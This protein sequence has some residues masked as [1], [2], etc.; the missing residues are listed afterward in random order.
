MDANV[1]AVIVTILG[2]VLAWLLSAIPIPSGR[3]WLVLKLAIT[4][5]A[6]IIV[7]S[8]PSLSQNYSLYFLIFL[9]SLVSIFISDILRFLGAYRTL[10]NWTSTFFSWNWLSTPV[11]A[12]WI[13]SLPI[14]VVV[15]TSAYPLVNDFIV[16]RQCNQRLVRN[17]K[18]IQQI[19]QACN[20]IINGKK[21]L[22]NA[23]PLVNR[24]R[25]SLVAWDRGGNNQSINDVA[26]RVSKDFN[27]AYAI[28]T[29]NPLANFY[30]IYMQEFKDLVVDGKKSC[31]LAYG[32]AEQPGSYKPVIDLYVKNKIPQASQESISVYIELGHFLINRD[33]D[34]SRAESFYKKIPENDPTR[35]DV[36]M[37]LG[38]IYFLKGSKKTGID[39]FEISRKYYK[40][41]F[42]NIKNDKSR[43]VGL[44][45]LTYNL[46][47]LEARLSSTVDASYG[48]AIDYLKTAYEDSKESFYEAHRDLAFAYFFNGDY[49]NSVDKFSDL[50]SSEKYKKRRDELIKEYLKRAKECKQSNGRQLESSS[51][52][53]ASDTD[54]S[55]LL[56]AGIFTNFIVHETIDP[57]FDIEHDSFYDCVLRR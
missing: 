21:S 2:I 41:A 54:K 24:G 45:D 50:I 44:A 53:S 33:R 56:K 48:N 49:K 42:E 3:K 46:G 40:E 19:Q 25:A 17:D 7:I 37:G 23:L 6:L 13:L 18:T 31:Q 1:S 29:L 32:S 47:A 26:E 22:N 35:S 28:D 27:D 16:L 39:D 36:L 20:S 14:I 52:C 57:F 4:T 55:R 11:L 10:A 8:I 30:K 12:P 43:R 9:L 15:C 5:I 51:S 34:Y 38:N